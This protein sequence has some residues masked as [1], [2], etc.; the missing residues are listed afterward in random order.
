MLRIKDILNKNF[1]TDP[2]NN[3]ET[4]L[5]NIQNIIL[6]TFVRNTI[7]HTYHHFINGLPHIKNQYSILQTHMDLGTHTQIY[8][9]AKKLHIIKFNTIESTISAF[10]SFY[11]T[12]T[13]AGLT[14]IQKLLF[15]TFLIILAPY[16]GPAIYYIL[17]DTPQILQSIL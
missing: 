2:S 10:N 14:I 9:T 1:D 13:N 7:D 5:Y 3:L 4:K 16:F 12:V 8:E 6:R 15:Y 17:A 11:N